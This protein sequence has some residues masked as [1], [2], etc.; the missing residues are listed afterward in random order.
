MIRK[1]MIAGVTVALTGAT[2]AYA[3]GGPGG[4]PRDCNNR[5]I[6]PRMAMQLQL[7]EAQVQ[8]LTELKKVR[9]EQAQQMRSQHQLAVQGVLTPEQYEQWQTMRQQRR[10]G[11]WGYQGRGMGNQ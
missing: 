10:H 8:Q 11:G 7:T 2:L 3:A 9:C 4:G 1:L 6:P 5:T